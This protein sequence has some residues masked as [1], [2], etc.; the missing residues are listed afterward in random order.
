MSRSEE[1][2][3]TVR[4]CYECA[5]LKRITDKGSQKKE[6]I[7]AIK[8]ESRGL[9]GSSYRNKVIQTEILL[10]LLSR[11]FALTLQDLAINIFTSNNSKAFER[12]LQKFCL[13]NAIHVALRKE[14]TCA[15]NQESCGINES[16]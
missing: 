5:V 14:K 1:F 6:K 2:T 11:A 4:A 9:N 15:N 12:K 8:Q 13:T 10:K 7:C 3:K 16:Y